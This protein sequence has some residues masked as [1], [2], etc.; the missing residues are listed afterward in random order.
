MHVLFVACSVF[1][2]MFVGV[3]VWVAVQHFIVQQC[4]RNERKQESDDHYPKKKAGYC[5][6][7][8]R[9]FLCALCLL[10]SS[11]MFADGYCQSV[12][13][14]VSVDSPLTFLSSLACNLYEHVNEG[15]R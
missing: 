14:A 13:F 5:A 10:S 6:V 8:C 7:H 1:S 15:R 12:G 3:A 4:L 9:S 11:L 2:L